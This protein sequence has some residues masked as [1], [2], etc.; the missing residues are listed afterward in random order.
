MA[1]T[2]HEGK[3]NEIFKWKKAVRLDPKSFKP[4]KNAR[5][6]SHWWREHK[7]KLAAR[8]LAHLLDQFCRPKD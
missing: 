6:Y 3:G 5:D 1:P 7:I 2:H 4:L 8:D